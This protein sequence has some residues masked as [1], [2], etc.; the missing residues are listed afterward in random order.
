M[1][2]TDINE[3]DVGKPDNELEGNG[4]EDEKSSSDE[5]SFEAVQEPQL[6]GQ[7]FRISAC[8]DGE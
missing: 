8:T 3:L 1:T 6:S 7:Y 5:F 4:L 2:S